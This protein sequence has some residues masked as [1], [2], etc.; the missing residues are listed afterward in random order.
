M[1]LLLQK[2]TILNMQE[3]ER[4][5][6]VDKTKWD[7]IEKPAPNLIAQSYLSKNANCTVRIRIKNDQGFLTIK[8]K[9]IGISRSEFEYEIPLSEA[10][11][12]METL[13]E[14]TLT[15]FR[16]NIPF[17][18]HIWEVDVFQGKLDGLIIAEIELQDENEA[19]EKPEWVIEDVSD[20]IEFYNSRLI[21]KC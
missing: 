6:S 16:Y 15:K 17:G 2:R 5:F 21:E 19:F 3:I 9:S 7:L 1:V 18:T 13:T 8:G 14:K 20:N 10:Q 12:M 11:A 4:K